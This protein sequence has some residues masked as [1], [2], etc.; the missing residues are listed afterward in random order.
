MYLLISP[1]VDFADL[2]FIFTSFF[3]V[4]A[5]GFEKRRMKQNSKKEQNH[6]FFNHRNIDTNLF[7]TLKKKLL[8]S[9]YFNMK[10]LFC[11]YRDLLTV[12]SS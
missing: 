6:Q 1:K 7:I 10:K 3:N 8:H 11:T 2:F 12:R 5:K 9:I 4:H